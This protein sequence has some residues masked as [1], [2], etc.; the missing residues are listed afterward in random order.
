MSF[1][2]AGWWTLLPLVRSRLAVTPIISLYAK[3]T[4][5]FCFF[6]LHTN[7]CEVQQLFLDGKQFDLWSRALSEQAGCLDQV[8]SST[9]AKCEVSRV[10]SF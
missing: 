7:K 1:R 8:L 5:Y 9:P 4:S 3:L 6:K 2:G 10:N